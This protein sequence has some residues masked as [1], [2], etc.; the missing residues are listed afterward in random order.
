[1]EKLSKKQTFLIGITLFSMFFG[2]GNLIF[3]PFLG[4]QAGT[5]AWVAFAG[6]AL[7][8]IGLPVLGVIAVAK[9]GGL[10]TLAGRVHPK[11]AAV[12]TFLIYLSIG[13]CLAIPRT[14]STSF[15]MAVLPFVPNLAENPMPLLIYS[16]VFFTVALILALR[17]DKL[18]ERLGKRLT[19]VLLTLIFVIFAACLIFPPGGYGAVTDAYLNNTL[20]KG[21]LDGYQTM[22]TIAALNFGIIIA[23]NIRALGIK[24]DKQVV[25]STIHA[26]WIAGGLLLAVYAAL[27]YVG[28]LTG[29]SFGLNEN[30]AQTL[31]AIVVNLFG[32]TGLVILAI[33]FVIACLNTCVGLISCC[34]EYFSEIFPRFSYKQWAVFFAVVSMV[35]SN[36]GLNAILKISIPVLNVLYPISIVLIA[37]AFLQKWLGRF[38]AVYPVGILFTGIISLISALAQN[39]IAIPVITPL[40]EKIPLYDMGLGW[41]IPAIVGILLG[42]VISGLNKKKA[43]EV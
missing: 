42:I 18:T 21:F 27:T 5:L 29:G 26:G 35:I 38:K 36:A 28:A 2:A 23:L 10:S 25:R 8:A 16:L 30:G 6:F 20:I 24:D 34:S 33:I 3:P 19:P 22:D 37:L 4:E 39:Q 43:C 13:P 41:V 7:S 11:F 15:E 9:S 1:M 12:F 31:T 32:K 17:P 40:I 14:A